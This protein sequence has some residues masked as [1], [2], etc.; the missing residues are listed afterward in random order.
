[1]LTKLKQEEGIASVIVIHDMAFASK[2]AD[3]LCFFGDGVIKEDALPGE[4]F[5]HPRT[6]GLRAFIDATGSEP[7]RVPVVPPPPP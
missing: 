5:T 1:M 4:A 6:P 2:A 3:R 7:R